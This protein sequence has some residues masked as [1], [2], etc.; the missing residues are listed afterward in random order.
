MRTLDG[1]KTRK[2][3]D[4]RLQLL[5]PHERV[6]GERVQPLRHDQAKALEAESR[7]LYGE[8]LRPASPAPVGAWRSSS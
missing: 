7:Q 1:C 5:N 6:L 8:L 4:R 2:A 3:A